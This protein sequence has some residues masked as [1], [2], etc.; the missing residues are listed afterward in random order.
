MLY[1]KVKELF[2]KKLILRIYKLSL[3]IKVKT[4]VLNFILRV[5]LAQQHPDEWHPVIYYS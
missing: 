2:T 4:D 3:L 1:K 5:Y